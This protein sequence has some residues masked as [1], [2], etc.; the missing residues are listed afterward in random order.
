[1]IHDC[2]PHAAAKGSLCGGMVALAG[3]GL[4]TILAIVSNDPERTRCLA[5]PR[6]GEDEGS[7]GA[8]LGRLMSVSLSRFNRHFL[9]AFSLRHIVA[10]VIRS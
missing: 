10:S 7:A 8:I 5:L 1:M 3:L 6:A 4:F 2:A 9:T